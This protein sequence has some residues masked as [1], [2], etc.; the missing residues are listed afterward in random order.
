MYLQVLQTRETL[1]AGG[2]MMRLLVGVCADVNQHFVPERYETSKRLQNTQTHRNPQTHLDNYR[3]M[4][5]IIMSVH[6]R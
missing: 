6:V 1:V 4:T 3:F 2:T 5:G